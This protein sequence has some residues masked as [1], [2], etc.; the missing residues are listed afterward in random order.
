MMEG[1][2]ATSDLTEVSRNR[3]AQHRYLLWRATKDPGRPLLHRLFGEAWCET[4]IN[5]FLFNG[6]TTLG[7]GKFLDYF[8]EYRLPDGSMKKDRSVAGK[9]CVHRPWDEQGNFTMS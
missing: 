5:D 8:P 3:Q 4:Y 9:S 6:V 1:A 7:A 2:K